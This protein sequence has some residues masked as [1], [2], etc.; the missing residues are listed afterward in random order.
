M[1]RPPALSFGP[2]LSLPFDG[3]GEYDLR[4]SEMNEK[5]LSIRED[6]PVSCTA[7]TFIVEI[8]LRA[9]HNG[10]IVFARPW[11]KEVPRVLG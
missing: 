7:D 4:M 2:T 5:E 9:R 10:T 8:D 3:S 11:R 1:E 6:D